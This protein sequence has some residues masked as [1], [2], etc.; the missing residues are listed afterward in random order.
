VVR[1][2]LQVTKLQKDIKTALDEVVAAR[3]KADMASNL[4]DVVKHASALL[5]KP[6]SP[7]NDE[8]SLKRKVWVSP[9]AR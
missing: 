4:A 6:K 8:R 3:K 1:L 5:L 9:A 7:R 2:E